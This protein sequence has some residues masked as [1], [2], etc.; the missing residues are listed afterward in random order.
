MTRRSAALSMSRLPEGAVQRRRTSL[1][2]APAAPLMRLQRAV[3]NRAVGQMLQAKLT[4]NRPGDRYEQEADQVAENVMRMPDPT[5]AR[6]AG[7]SSRPA[8]PRIQR[9]CPECEDQM[10]RKPMDEEEEEKLQAKE[11]PGA[12]P[13]VT[14]QVQAGVDAM[15]GGGQPL[16]APVRAFFEPRF[17]QDFSHVRLHAD[18]RAA[19]TA[20]SVNARAFTVGRDIAF[21]AG[22]YAPGTAAGQRLLAHELTHVV[23]QG[24]PTRTIDAGAQSTLVMQRKAARKKPSARPKQ[25]SKKSLER[26]D[27]VLL[28]GSGQVAEATTLSPDG[29]Q[30]RVDSPAK[31][32]TELKRIRFPIKTLFIMSH[33]LPS[34]DLGFESGGQTHYV[35][36]TELASKLKGIVAPENSPET[37]DF[38]GCSIGTS[39]KEMDRIRTAVGAKTAIGST[40]FLVNQANGPI[41]IDGSQITSTKQLTKDNRPVFEEGMKKLKNSFGKAKGCILDES[42]AAYFR[43]GGKLVALWASPTLDTKWDERKSICY[44]NLPEETVDPTTARGGDVESDLVGHCKLVKV[45]QAAP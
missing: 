37:L 30:V 32:A 43:A 36:P 11:S 31:M 27:V 20:R 45:L 29:M 4:V 22:E 16:P 19:D 44:K 1:P 15:R 34:G 33:S 41:R 26:K 23:Q 7:V 14:P 40:C 10:H 18:A 42:E 8:S 5:V 13:T 38:R 2:A 28:L 17:G 25:P 24:I 9:L 39:P 21:G 35:M 3:G 12:T 6:G